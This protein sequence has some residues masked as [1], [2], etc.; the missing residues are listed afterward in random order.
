MVSF[1]R[2]S[3]ALEGAGVCVIEGRGAF[4]LGVGVGFLSPPNWMEPVGPKRKH[5]DDMG[6]VT[7]YTGISNGYK[8]PVWS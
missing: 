4:W 5:D 2:V 3:R 1:G 6:T 7:S 8:G